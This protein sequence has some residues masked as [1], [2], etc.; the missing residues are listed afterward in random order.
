M[1]TV[2]DV[3]TTCITSVDGVKLIKLWL[4]VSSP[5]QTDATLLDVT[6]CV[7]LLT[8]LHVVAYCWELLHPFAHHNNSQHCWTNN[9]GS[10]CVH[11]HS[12]A[13]LKSSFNVCSLHRGLGCICMAQKGQRE[14]TITFT[15][16]KLKYFE[17]QNS[18]E[19]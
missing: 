1:L 10:R 4:L 5:T 15:F 17:R 19:H 2:T 3:S 6:C 11:L 9:A 14:I 12:L 13:N 8:L 7:R 16:V 18:K